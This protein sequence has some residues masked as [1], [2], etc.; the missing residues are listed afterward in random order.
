M[1]EVGHRNA[2]SIRC[3]DA[4]IGARYACKGV[5]RGA[6]QIDPILRPAAHGYEIGKD[7]GQRSGGQPEVRVSSLYS[8]L[9]RMEGRGWIKSRWVE[10]TGVR[11][12]CYYTLTP[13][14]QEIL[15]R[16]RREWV[17]FSTMVNQVIGASHA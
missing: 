9:Y 14:G 13:Q 12:R 11:R 3:V 8:I 5:R 16:Q 4:Q 17:A 2:E 6:V 7:L 10:K 15:A 1:I